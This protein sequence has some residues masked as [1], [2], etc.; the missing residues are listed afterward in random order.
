MDEWAKRMN[1]NERQLTSF[2]QR[3]QQ[4]CDSKENYL[5]NRI[6]EISKCC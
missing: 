3:K 5:L 6:K 1:E 2:P 4:G